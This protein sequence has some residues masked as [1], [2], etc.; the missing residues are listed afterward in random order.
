L[1]GAHVQKANSSDNN[2]YICP[3]CISHN[4]SIDDLEIADW[5]E[6]APAN[7]KETCDK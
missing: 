4:Q 3:L 6:L 2:W 5:I 7:K 1:V